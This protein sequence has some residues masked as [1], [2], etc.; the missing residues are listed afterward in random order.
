M[1]DPTRRRRDLVAPL[2]DQ[3][4]S[5]RSPLSAPPLRASDPLAADSPMG[6]QGVPWY[7]HVGVRTGAFFLVAT[8]LAVLGQI[9]RLGLGL[10][11]TGAAWWEPI[12]DELV[13]IVLA[14]GVVTTLLEARRPASSTHQR[15]GR[16]CLRA[17]SAAPSSALSSPA[18]SGCS[19]G[20]CSPGRTRTRRGSGSW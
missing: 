3:T 7:R 16:D 18:S 4:G 17:C 9:V 10:D 6:W 5:W 2:N 11:L 20:L 8:A 1:S 19:A 14:Y 12:I 13:P 15:A